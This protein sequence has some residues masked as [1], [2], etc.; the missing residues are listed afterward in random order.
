MTLM[1]VAESP[2]FAATD[3]LFPRPLHLVRRIE[4]PLAKKPVT[5]DEYCSGNRTITIH[6]P[7]VTIIDYDQQSVTE[8]DHAGGT[9]SI[10]RFD[11]IAKSRD[12]QVQATRQTTNAAT[13]LTASHCKQ[14][15]LGMKSSSAGR[16][17][18]S[19]ELVAGDEHELRRIEISVDRH[20]P[21]S[22]GAGAGPG[23][24]AW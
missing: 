8:I 11:E 19:Y 22:R 13:T 12:R 6:G 24:P 20:I 1:V 21:L 5:M 4:D 15:E 9:Y 18:D 10:T 23:G 16:S 2:A 17:V 3:I 7:H 14:T